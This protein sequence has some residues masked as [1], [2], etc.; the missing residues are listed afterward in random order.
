MPKMKKSEF[1]RDKANQVDHLTVSEFVARNQ[2]EGRTP[3]Q[4][5]AFSA[6]FLSRSQN[7][8][9]IYES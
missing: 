1:V 6:V 2:S 4:T 5:S 7:N 8:L 3:G 9:I